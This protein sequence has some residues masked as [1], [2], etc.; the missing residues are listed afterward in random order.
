MSDIDKV[1]SQ[2]DRFLAFSFASADLFLEVSGS[3]IVEYALGAGKSLAGVN[4]Q[5]I[6]GK[7]WLDL[8]DIRNHNKLI[9]LY[10]NSKIAE[11]CGPLQVTMDEKIGGGRSA[12]L[13]AIKMPG[14]DKI[15]V[16]IGFPSDLMTRLA[17]LSE[18]REDFMLL[19][20]D[21]FLDSA[22]EAID[23][24]RQMGQDIDMTLLD[25]QA[26]HEA[27]ERLGEEWWE[28]FNQAVTEL[29]GA[30]SVDG[31]AAAMIRDGRYSIIHNKDITSDD[32]RSRLETLAK[33]KD[34]TGEGFTVESK[35]VSAD[36]QTLSQ[37]DASKAL[38]YTIN[39]FERK[40]TSL[41]IESL[42]SGFKAYVSA[43]A[44]KIQQFKT[45]VE[46]SHFELHF[47]PIVD[48]ETYECSHFEMLSRFKGQESTQEWII[49][50]EDIGM[51]AEFDIAV[52]ER[53]INYMMYKS[54]GRRTKFA[55]NLSGQSIQNEQFFKTLLTKLSLGKDL[56][57]RLIFEITEST[58]I[59]NLDMVNNFIRTL[60]DK[61][62]SVCLDDFG[63][64]SASFQYL[65]KLHVNYV[66]IDGQYTRKILSSERDLVM[67]RNLVQMC[68]DLGINVIAEQ[69]EKKEQCDLMRELKIPF[70]QGFLFSKAT[71]KPEYDPSMV[72]L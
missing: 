58:T 45:M 39:E 15:Y 68:N 33:E 48:L 10:K 19:D 70:G 56:E 2:R 23:I 63:A 46:Q 51:A 5:A 29:L 50:G 49:F 1:K 21:T 54:Q 66:K 62:Y 61:G 38:I 3:G 71:P 18:Q 60:Q 47:Q 53:A 31:Q 7:K 9:D 30:T 37:R 16:T 12:I 40:G 25:I 52:C 72:K 13:T 14:S 11:R 65:H 69:I 55:I 6:I 57:K 34:P 36:L 17:T 41:N 32:L 42:N 28:Q 4:D 43:N 35:T 59:Q 27:R 24:A 67:V 22:K 8:F 20:K 64:G 26:A 44:H